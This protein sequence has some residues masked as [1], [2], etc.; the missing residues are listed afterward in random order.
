M[1]RIIAAL[2]ISGIWCAPLA[3]ADTREDD[4]LRLI[5]RNYFSVNHTDSEW[6]AE[7]HKICN[8]RLRGS[9]DDQL[10]HMV[11]ADLNVSDAN[12]RIV[13]AEAQGVVC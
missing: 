10:I 1:I 9:T 2:L 8:A 5:H 13:I 3:Q 11:E 6:L 7:A 4:Y 12:S